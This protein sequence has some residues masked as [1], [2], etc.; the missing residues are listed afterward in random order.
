M[1]VRRVEWTID[2]LKKKIEES[3]KGESIW[4]PEFNAAGIKGMQLEFL[5]NGR[6][7]THYEGFCSLFLWCPSG[8]KIRYQLWIEEHLRAPDEDEY[9]GRM[10]HGHSNFCNLSAEWEGDC[11]SVKVG[12]DILEV[13]SA[14]ASVPK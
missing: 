1:F 2:E 5:P 14:G 6:E 10:G 9:D 11:A 8:T 13:K 12:V 4:S 3:P 7:T